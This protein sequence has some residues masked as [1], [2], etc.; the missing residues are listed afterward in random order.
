MTKYLRVYCDSFGFGYEDWIPCEITGKTAVDIHHI[1][2]RENRI[3]NLMAV[4]REIHTEFGEIKSCMGTLL[5]RHREVLTMRKIPFDREW[6][7][8]K[9]KEYA[10]HE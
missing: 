9:I 7:R 2:T 1:C 5:R 3:E 10:Q 4:T 6:F 8:S